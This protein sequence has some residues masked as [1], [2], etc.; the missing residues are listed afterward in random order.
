MV[1]IL[2]KLCIKNYMDYHDL[3]V[4][5]GYGILCSVLGIVLNLLLVAVKMIAGI[6]S[7]SV[8]VIADAV[9]NLS[10]AASSLITLLGFWLGG[11]AP[12]PEHPFGHGRME[13]LAGLAVS[14]LILYMGVELLTSSIQS[15]LAPVAVV[16]SVPTMILLCISVPIKL[17]MFFF[18]HSIGKKIDSPAMQATAMDSISDVISTTVVIISTVLSAT[19]GWNMDG[20]CGILVSL[21]ILRAG[22][23]S[24]KDT[25]S[26]L[27]GQPPSK[28]LVEEIHQ[29]VLS[30]EMIVGVHDMVI[31][32]Y[33][34]GR[35]MISLHA[36]VPANG[37]IFLLHDMIDNVER[38]LSARFACDAVIHM[39]P[40]A[41][42]DKAIS[43]MRVAVAK[44]IGTV[45]NDITMHDFRM[46]EGHTHTNLIFDVCVP[47]AFPM[48]D[49]ELK[50]A[51]EQAI[52]EQFPHCCA[53]I[54]VD[55]AYV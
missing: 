24:A 37:D 32:N 31:H 39:D 34:P 20:I 11:K 4:R 21:L 7:G 27:L 1:G 49:A 18:H 52:V 54:K 5:K 10:D 44:I 22:F 50:A 45:H 3:Q 29:I 48:K 36:E 43:A 53:V 14:V 35:M 46:V 41:V 9:N 23:T 42:D 28:E 47:F 16:L 51:I 25:I 6:F 55:K 19:F 40:I 12:D 2:A 30:H 26:P 13:Y 8:A 17:Y 38:E 33:G 15:L